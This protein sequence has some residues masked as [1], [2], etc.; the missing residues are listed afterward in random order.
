MKDKLDFSEIYKR[1]RA[2]PS[3][4]GDFIKNIENFKRSEIKKLIFSNLVMII[5]AVAIFIFLLMFKPQM[6]LTKIGAFFTA[7]AFVLYFIYYNQLFISLKKIDYTKNNLDFLSNLTAHKSK[8]QFI[9]T[10]V[11]NIYFACMT[12]GL[13]AYLYEYAS[14]KDVFTSVLIY[15]ITLAW[16]GVNWFF[17]RPK[18]VRKEQKKLDAFIDKYREMT[19]RIHE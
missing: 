18:T 9:N 6:L 19:N 14:Q 10:T 1:Q 17:I 15:S 12:V 5:T 3:P 8:R 2:A 4:P 11:L 7:F 13:C 16:I